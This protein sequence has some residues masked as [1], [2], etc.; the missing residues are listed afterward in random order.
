MKN[1]SRSSED[2][3]GHESLKERFGTHEKDFRTFQ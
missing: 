3:S 2:S 1:I